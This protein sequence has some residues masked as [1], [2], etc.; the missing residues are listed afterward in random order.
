MIYLHIKPTVK[1]IIQQLLMKIAIKL[2]KEILPPATA[3][4][5]NLDSPYMVWATSKMNVVGTFMIRWGIH[6]V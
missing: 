4:P 5:P 6:G 3:F 2:L 1:K